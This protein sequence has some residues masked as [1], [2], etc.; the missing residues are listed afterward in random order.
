MRIVC[1]P[2]RSQR[3]MAPR[4]PR[5][6]S[7]VLLVLLLP[8][9]LPLS[10]CAGL[11][12]GRTSEEGRA[13]EAEK[14]AEVA[15]FRRDELIDP[16]LE[17]VTDPA[18]VSE[19]P[20]TD[21]EVPDPLRLVDAIRIA[22]E[23][24]REYQARRESL[25]L[26]AIDLGVTRRDFLRPVFDGSVNY[27]LSDAS[28][29]RSS[30]VAS[31]SLGGSYLTFGG[32]TLSV[33]TSWGYDRVSDGLGPDQSVSGGTTV[34]FSQPLL[35]GAG[36]AIAFEGLTQAER[37]LLYEARSFELF[38][39]DFVIRII[40]DYYALL[41]QEQQLENTRQNIERQQFA[42]DQAQALFR[43]GRGDSLS[44]FRAEQSL[45]QAQDQYL[46]AEQGFAVALDRFKIDLGLPTEVEFDVEDTF[47]DLNELALDL[48]AAVRAA[49]HNRL[50]LVTERDRLEDQRRSVTIARDR[51]LPNFNLSASWSTSSDSQSSLRQLDFHERDAASIGFALEIPF[52]RK[53][54][55]ASLRS[56]EISLLQ[57]ERDLDRTEDQVILEVR[58]SLGTLRQRRTQI[59]IGEK[60]IRS[61]ELSLEKA[62]LEF[63]SGLATNRDV[64]EAADQLTDAQNQQLDRIVD[65]EIARLTL[66]RQLGLLFVDDSGQVEE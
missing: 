1:R 21:I 50:D 17:G 51:I 29:L 25:F 27:T 49:L 65:H 47:P 6:R 5:V 8:A 62:S 2:D 37:S 7:R 20:V 30:D 53:S 9:L 60:E 12:G 4:P 63:E 48:D 61:L 14:R 45:L 43:L 42:Y 23:H 13:I 54:E 19:A 40:D 36:N 58:N 57:A 66:L 55:Q 10:G 41:S 46:S 3:G 39:Q 34:S 44:V 18:E 52:D 15:A 33:D 24:S 28:D 32:G 56:A 38:R 26:S 31:L 11:W 64:T 16:R 22:T 59:E 35:R